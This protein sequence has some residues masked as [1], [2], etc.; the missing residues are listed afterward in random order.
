MPAA[1]CTYV[2]MHGTHLNARDTRVE[3]EE[4]QHKLLYDMEWEI[5][6][7]CNLLRPRLFFIR[8]LYLLLY[9]AKLVCYIVSSGW[10]QNV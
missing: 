9:E 3:T 4:T 1:P 10:L 2:R 6:V 8:V 5:C 7:N